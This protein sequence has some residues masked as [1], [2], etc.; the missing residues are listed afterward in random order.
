MLYSISRIQGQCLNRP[1]NGVLNKI[2][3]CFSEVPF[4]LVS[5]TMLIQEHK[6]VSERK[7]ACSGQFFVYFEFIK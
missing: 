4:S 7:L 3:N 1:V 6:D 2:K 5:V